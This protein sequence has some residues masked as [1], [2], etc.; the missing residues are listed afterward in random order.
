V[1]VSSFW[2]KWGLPYFGVREG[3][4]IMGNTSMEK[5]RREE[6]KL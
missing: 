6:K 1:C 4:T 5:G 2:L 3:S